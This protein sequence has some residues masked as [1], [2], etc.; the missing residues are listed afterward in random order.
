MSDRSSHCPFLNRADARCSNHFSLDRLGHAF[1]YCFG[2]Y[3]A[4]PVYLELL[5]ERRVRRLTGSVASQ[6]AG[7]GTIPLVQITLQGRRH[8][9]ADRHRLN[10]A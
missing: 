3:Q 4:C 8:A 7:D 9:A 5:V 6:G 1:G 10:A 2:Q